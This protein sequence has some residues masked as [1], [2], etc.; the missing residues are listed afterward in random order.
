MPAPARAVQVAY[1]GALILRALTGDGTLS[2]LEE[3]VALT[4]WSTRVLGAGVV[5]STY[6]VDR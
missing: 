2:P 1:N 6:A 4:H 3:D 5:Q